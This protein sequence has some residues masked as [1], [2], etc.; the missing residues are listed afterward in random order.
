MTRTGAVFFLFV[1]LYAVVFATNP[2]AIR[3]RVALVLH[4]SAD[5]AYY[6]AQMHFNATSSDAYDIST[7]KY[8][9]D[10][11][12][13]LDSDYPYVHHQLARI[14]FLNGDYTR[15]LDEINI[16]IANDPEK[17][18][19][20]A[21]YVRGLVE[22]Y[23]QDY[24]AAVRDYREFVALQPDRW[25]GRTDLAW[26]LIKTGAYDEAL[27]VIDEGLA[28]DADNSWLLSV[29]ATVLFEQGKLADALVS[30]R[31]AAD[32]VEQITLDQWLKAYPGNAPAAAPT[33]IKTLKEAARKNLDMIRDAARAQGIQ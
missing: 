33:G 20:S 14:H 32:A 21:Y 26:V 3:E 30:A 2:W 8:F 17:K 22:G 15:A 12:V 4:P 24:D 10:R 11:T 1:A 9:Y 6:F 7:A 25:E 16:E 23:L 13:A 27:R 19:A 28:R 5:T 18:N 29:R 31:R